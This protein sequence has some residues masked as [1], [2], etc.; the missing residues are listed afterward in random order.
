MATGINTQFSQPPSDTSEV[1][2]IGIVRGAVDLAAFQQREILR[3]AAA[4]DKHPLGGSH[5]GGD[6][7]AVGSRRPLEGHLVS[8]AA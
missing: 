8:P 2:S 7:E 5:L 3:V 6:D 1:R 4:S